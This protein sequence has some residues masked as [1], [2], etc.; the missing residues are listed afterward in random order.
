[1]D[2]QSLIICWLTTTMISALHAE[3]AQAQPQDSTP[4]TVTNSIGMRFV[5]IP[6]REFQ[7]GS[8][9]SERGRRE[10]E[11]QHRVK[12]TKP[13]YL[14]MFEVT[15]AEYLKIMDENPSKFSPDGPRGESVVGIDTIRL[16]VDSV[17]WDN[18]VEFCRHLSNL[19]VE[20]KSKRSYRLPTEAEWEYA[21]RAGSSKLWSHGDEIDDLK[22]FAWYGSRIAEGRTHQ[23]GEKE[24]NH[25][26]L[27][28]MHGNVWEWCHDWYTDDLKHGGTVVDPQGPKSGEL[29]VIRGG[30]WAS[31]PARCRN[32][33]R[34]HDPPSVHDEDLGF[35]VVLIQ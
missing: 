32:A 29:R 2:Y 23:V 3:W 18:A 27:H 4:K 22:S 21:C 20:S 5:Y 1:M 16:P 35:R 12:I 13:F 6:A 15:Q 8:P 10:N 9:Q 14:G 26:G 30:G 7:M 24:P 33:A 19:P 34:S 28:D 17:S 25:F 31:G 11:H